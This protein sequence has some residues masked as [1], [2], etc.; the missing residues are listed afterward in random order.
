[1]YRY[2]ILTALT[3]LPMLVCAQGEPEQD[4]GIFIQ[5]ERSVGVYLNSNGVGADFRFAK[6][7]DGF[8]KRIIETGICNIKHPKEIKTHNSNNESESYVYGKVNNFLNIRAG[9]GRQ[10]EMFSKF[11]KGSIAI[12]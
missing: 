1:M 5:N 11:D 9:I 12:R 4:D 8:R 7:L 2:F 10:K 3:F 6:R